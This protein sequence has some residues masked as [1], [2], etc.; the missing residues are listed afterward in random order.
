[1]SLRFPGRGKCDGRTLEMNGTAW[2]S[3]LQLP[4][5][6]RGQGA[7]EGPRGAGSPGQRCR[8]HAFTRPTLGQARSLSGTQ[9]LCMAPVDENSADLG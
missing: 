6:Q 3:T 8:A 7:S 2:N 9:F 5:P 4:E 1:M